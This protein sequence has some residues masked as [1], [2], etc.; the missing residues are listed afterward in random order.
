MYK[1][2]IV[3]L[4]KT[5]ET[6]GQK[7]LLANLNTIA[8]LHNATVKLENSKGILPCA[9]PDDA[10][11]ILDDIHDGE[12]RLSEAKTA[13]TDGFADINKMSEKNLGKKF[14]NDGLY[15]FCKK[16]VNELYDAHEWEQVHLDKRIERHNELM[17]KFGEDSS[18]PNMPSNEPDF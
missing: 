2:K 11:W 12:K 15:D 9:E 3:E 13:A 14:S 16:F 6:D 1:E 10:M 7:K 8:D 18:T 17:K 5:L 4:G